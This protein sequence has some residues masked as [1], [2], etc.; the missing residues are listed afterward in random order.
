MRV[1]VSLKDEV[2]LRKEVSQITSKKTE[3]ASQMEK[4]SRNLEDE[5]T[6][7]GSKSMELVLNIYTNRSNN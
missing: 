2:P 7:Y 6:L 3:M 5:N 1:S 4:I